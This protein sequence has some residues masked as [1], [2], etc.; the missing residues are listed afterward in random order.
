MTTVFIGGS[1]HISRLSDAT[2]NRLNNVVAK[3]FP[4]VVG[5][6]AG[7]DKA[8]QKFLL[9]AGCRDV[10]V[11]CTGERCR[12]N[13]GDWPVRRVDA[14]GDGSGFASG[15]GDG[16]GSGD[17]S[18]F[19]S[20]SGDGRGSGDGSGIASGAGNGK[21][22]GSGKGFAFY[23]AK[24]REMARVADAGLMIWD[25]KSPGTMLNVLR[26]VRAGKKAVL[27][28]VPGGRTLTF[29]ASADW[30]DFLSGVSPT[31][32]DDLRKRATPEEWEGS[33]PPRQGSL[34]DLPP[35][36]TD[37]ELAAALDAALAAGDSAS[38]VD[39]LGGIARARGM[40]QVA[41]DT[42]LARESLYRS[43][44]AGGNPEFATVLKVMASVGLRLRLGRETGK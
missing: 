3:G 1:R 11:Y 40:S 14:G 32:R 19:A 44:T 31:F 7:A 25:G 10:T 33:G 16:R 13:L 30:D 23:A 41:K 35:A 28:D 12:N 2:R 17:G 42:G 26:L 15:A 27:L 29:A 36:R 43:L 39:A 37:A 21:G 18:G 34:L 38:V 4:V 9:D 24:D 8:V 6:A 20:G 5:D 22:S